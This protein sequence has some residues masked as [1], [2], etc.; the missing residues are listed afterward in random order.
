MISGMVG[1]KPAH[2]KCS[3][4]FL[5]DSTNNTLSFDAAT[6]S[7]LLCV[8]TCLRNVNLSQ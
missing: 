7:R 5:C 6:T 1:A 8:A 3:K 4:T 2:L